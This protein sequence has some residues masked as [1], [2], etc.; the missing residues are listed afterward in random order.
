MTGERDAA[1]ARGVSVERF[2]V[3]GPLLLT[4]IVRRDD[5]GY[6]LE[7]WRDDVCAAVGLDARFVQ[8]NL[9]RSRRGVLRGLHFQRAPHQQ[10]KLVSVVRGRVLDVIVDLRR[11][12]PTFLR[13]L[14]VLLDDEAHR[15]L[16]VPPGFAHGF[17]ALGEVNDVLYKVD[18]YHAPAAEG[19]VRWDDPA[20]D[21]DWGQG[22]PTGRRPQ[23]LVSPR[24]ASLPHLVDTQFDF[25]Y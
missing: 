25:A 8:D 7:R 19:G 16:W 5:R 13:H 1:A 11:G 21:I 15:Q 3:P 22:R 6:F 10:G 2:D 14:A 24:D 12:S 20:L 23:P 4:P 9:S 18:A 17:L